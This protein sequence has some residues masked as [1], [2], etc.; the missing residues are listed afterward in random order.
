MTNIQKIFT[1]FIS[2]LYNQYNKIF[3]KCS[4]NMESIVFPYKLN[5]NTIFP[6]PQY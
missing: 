4:N 5:N 6:V 2:V 1:N 3:I